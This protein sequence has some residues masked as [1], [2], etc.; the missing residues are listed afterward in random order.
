MEFC[1]HCMRPVTSARCGHCGGEVQ[2]QNPAHLLP[3]GSVLQRGPNGGSYQIGAY[4]GQGGFGVTYI[5]MELETGRRTAVKEYF[6]TRCARRGEGGQ[7][8]P[9]P[10]QDAVFEGGRFTFLQEAR[11]LASLEGM[12]AVVQGLDYLELNNTAYLVMEFLDGTPLYR[13]VDSRGR[14]PAEE[15]LPRLEPL[16][17]DIARL[18][19]AG[20]I[21]RDI[22]P[23]NLMWLKSGAIKLMDFG[24]ARSIEDGK[25]MTVALKQ[26]FAPVEQ[27][28]TRGQG[29]W[30]DV[31]ALCAT[32]YYCLTGKVPPSAP[33]R[34]MGEDLT[35]PNALGAGLTSGQEQT[36]LWGLTVD[37][38]QR[39]ANMELFAR[40][41][42]PE[43]W[44]APLPG[45]AGTAQV[46]TAR[47]ETL[48]GPAGTGS[49]AGPADT[50]RA[51]QPYE[52]CARRGALALWQQ[53][54]AW[55][56][57]QMER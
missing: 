51:Y 33:D 35:P 39:P 11:M 34:L 4:L 19:A 32:L 30:T 44:A 56:R 52:T 18:H 1:P 57:E 43:A 50:G 36:L 8:L 6:P 10:G 16:L 14:I 49:T 17:R 12:P 21:H 29:P 48:P 55:L 20:V 46:D 28:R 15:L 25:S 41:L 13:L 9:L 27:Y 47:T 42:F 31:Y 37:P 53:A 5:A 45:G 26:G 24:C 3:V 38:K 23:D 54:V 2:W 40:Q 7:V 22:S